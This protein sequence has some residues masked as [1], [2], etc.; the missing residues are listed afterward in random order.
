MDAA[1]RLQRFI[2][3]RLERLQKMVRKYFLQGAAGLKIPL[4]LAFCWGRLLQQG[5]AAARQMSNHRLTPTDSQ[6]SLM[7]DTPRPAIRSPLTTRVASIGFFLGPILLLTFL[8]VPPPGELARDTWVTLGLLLMM[9]CWWATEA[10]PLPVTSLL[11]LALIPLLGLGTV[12]SAAA[13]YANHVIFLF[14][15]GFMLGLA[16]QRWQ[17][18][19]RI[20]LLTLLAVGNQPRNQIGGF[21]LATGLIGMWVSNTATAVM[22]LPIALSVVSLL[23]N[24]TDPAEQPARQRFATK[25]LLGIAYA[26]SIGGI[27]TLIATPA[28]AMLAAYLFEHHD[29]QIGFVQWMSIGMPVAA[30]MMLFTWW[31]LT[32]GGF[33][34]PVQDSRALLRRELLALGP[35]SAGEK[36]ISLV[37]VTVA[38]AWVLRPLLARYLPGLTDAGIAM[39]MAIALFLIPANWKERVFLMDWEAT[40]KLPWGVLLLFGGGLSLAGVITSSGLAQWIA[41]SLGGLGA[42]PVILMIGLVVL[43]INLFT[44]VTSNTATAAA[45]LPLMGALAVAQGLPPELLAVPVAIAASCS[46]IMPVATPPNALVFGTGHVAL[47][48]MMRAGLALNIFGVI[49][50]TVLSY[51]IVG[52]LWRY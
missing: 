18:H 26:A 33:D 5:G 39:I 28:N 14:M 40:A 15:G 38:L 43:V 19:R 25:L 2:L 1:L 17:L 21:M 23:G 8:L 41:G 7:T 16:M 34:F 24:G 47:P 32:R 12:S 36:R 48:A 52:L 20:A 30:G 3:L 35:M 49:L 51:L 13:P 22:M 42:L 27:T 45:F 50:I 29:I 9:A 11:P 4:Y 46:F 31:W 37:F 10:I 44:E 6:G